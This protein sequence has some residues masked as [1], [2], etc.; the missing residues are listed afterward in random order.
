MFLTPGERIGASSS[1][2]L[3]SG[4]YERNG[5]IRATVVGYKRTKGT[6]VCVER[7]RVAKSQIPK[8]GDVVLGTVVRVNER[9]ATL[10]ILVVVCDYSISYCSWF[11]KRAQ[12]QSRIPFKALSV[13]RIS[14]PEKG[15]RY[16]LC[17][18]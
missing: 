7:K 6:S 11:L 17:S 16:G 14:G 5:S 18:M 15:K 8:V 13:S 10:M 2:E 1:S 9:F 12:Y 3:S 4:T